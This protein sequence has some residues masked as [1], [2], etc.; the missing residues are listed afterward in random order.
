MCKVN[1]N[2]YFSDIVDRKDCLEAKGTTVREVIEDINNKYP[3]FKQEC[4]D[5]Q[6]KLYGFLEVY[7]NLVLLR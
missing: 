2:P 7:I 3:G 4:I 6:D 5:K 1:L